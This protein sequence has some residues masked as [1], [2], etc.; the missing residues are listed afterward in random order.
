MIKIYCSGILDNVFDLTLQIWTLFLYVNGIFKMNLLSV[1]VESNKGRDRIMS[2]S[3]GDKKEVRKERVK[4]KLYLDL[5][6][7]STHT[8]NIHTAC[9]IRGSHSYRETALSVLYVVKSHFPSLPLSK[10]RQ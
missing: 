10:I 9:S 6:S 1:D 7:F 8:H 2:L 5:V 3:K 4:D